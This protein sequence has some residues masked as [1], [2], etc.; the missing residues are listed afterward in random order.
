M[1]PVCQTLQWVVEGPPLWGSSQRAE[2][3]Q[4]TETGAKCESALEAAGGWLRVSGSPQEGGRVQGMSVRVGNTR[5]TCTKCA[6][7]E[8]C[9]CRD[10]APPAARTGGSGHAGTGVHRCGQRQ[11]ARAHPLRSRVA[12]AGRS[13]R[14]VRSSQLRNHSERTSKASRGLGHR[15]G[16]AAQKHGDPGRWWEA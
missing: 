12:W 6:G 16:S 10:Q 9:T 11:Q 4:S 15:P 8:G 1:P 5:R 13:G 2:R 3:S 14:G 7:T